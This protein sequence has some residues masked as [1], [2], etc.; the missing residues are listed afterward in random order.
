MLKLDTGDSIA[1]VALVVASCALALEVRRWVEAGPGV[2]L[3]A[4]P[5]RSLFTKFGAKAETG[6]NRVHISITNTGSATT[7]I[8]HVFV[9]DYRSWFFRWRD[10]AE[11]Y[12]VFYDAEKKEEVYELK[13]GGMFN[14]EIHPRDDELNIKRKD[15]WYGVYCTHRRQPYLC[16]LGRRT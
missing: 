9:A 5:M 3:Q 4:S 15:L 10:R 16:K 14:I 13:P 7:N 12:T 8:T 11:G 1:L 6:E 2:R